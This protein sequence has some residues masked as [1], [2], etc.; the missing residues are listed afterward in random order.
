MLR[1]WF[2]RTGSPSA[3]SKVKQKVYIPIRFSVLLK[4][5]NWAISR[6]ADFEEYKQKLFADERMNAKF[7][8]FRKLVLPNLANIFASVNSVDLKVI[9]ISSVHLP[10]KMKE[11]LETLAKDL[12]YIDIVYA[13]ETDKLVSLID[14]QIDRDVRSYGADV[15]YATVRLDDDDMLGHNFIPKVEKYLN[16]GFCDHIISFSRGYESFA[17][18]AEQKLSP[19]LKMSSPKIA[20]GLT[21]INFYSN[22]QKR[23]LASIG[24][25]YAAGDHTMVQENFTLLVDQS[26]AMYLRMSY[27]QQD[28]MAKGIFGRIKRR[29]GSVV[30]TEEVTE[31]FPELLNLFTP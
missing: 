1:H 28:T 16:L 5:K 11:Q 24:N 31:H 14:R 3:P 17:D 4:S 12:A 7:H 9:I 8:L 27:L 6:T 18:L 21:H 10:R 29:D 15:A 30:E 2:G 25:I 22:V 13:K 19:H 23:H 26:R 20:L